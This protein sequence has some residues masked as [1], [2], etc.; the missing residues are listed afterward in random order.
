MN[1]K[2]LIITVVV[3]FIT[4]WATDFLIHAVWLSSTYGATKEL[5][6][7]EEEMMS[8]MPWMLL[9]QLLIASAFTLIFAAAVA[10]KRHL[11]CSLKY[12]ATMGVLAIGGQIIM[13]AVQPLPGLLVAKW[14]FSYFVQMLLLGLIVHK[15]YKPL[16]K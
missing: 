9:G 16:P 15:V 7:P 13:Y 14:C 10:E 4:V 5:W 2:S 3:A 11:A 1:T 12:A 8:K 6:R